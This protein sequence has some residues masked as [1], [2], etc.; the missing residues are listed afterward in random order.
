MRQ[1]NNSKNNIQNISNSSIIII[2]I[3]LWIVCVLCCCHFKNQQRVWLCFVIEPLLSLWTYVIADNKQESEWEREREGAI[4]ERLKQ[5]TCN[6]TTPFFKRAQLWNLLFALRVVINKLPGGGWSSGSHY[7][8][9][10][11]WG[12]RWVWVWGWVWGSG[13]FPLVSS[14]TLSASYFCV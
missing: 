8:R 3:Y 1:H 5:Q 7:S 10:T 13:S 2:I 4:N 6:W 11:D 9:S 14:V 12:W